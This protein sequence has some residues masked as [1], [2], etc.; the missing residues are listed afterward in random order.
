M[1]DNK[2]AILQQLCDEFVPVTISFQSAQRKRDN[3][4]ILLNNAIDDC[5]GNIEAAAVKVRRELSGEKSGSEPVKTQEPKPEQTQVSKPEPVQE[6]TP[7]P[8]PEQ[9]Q[10]SEPVQAQEPELVQEQTQEQVSEP[11]SVQEQISE[12]TT[13][14]Q[15]TL[16]TDFPLVDE[17][18]PVDT[19]PVSSEPVN[20]EINDD[21]I[22]DDSDDDTDDY[23]DDT[24]ATDFKAVFGL[25]K[26]DDI[27][28][29]IPEKPKKPVKKLSKSKDEDI[30]MKKA[31]VPHSVEIFL[32]SIFPSYTDA[33]FG[34]KISAMAYILS[35][36]DCNEISQR[37]VTIAEDYEKRQKR[38]RGVTVDDIGKSLVRLRNH[39][40]EILQISYETR[41]ATAY[42]ELQR[43]YSRS[44]AP[45]I[46]NIDFFS[47]D[48]QKY[49][50]RLHTLAER[51][52]RS[53]IDAR[54]RE[55]RKSTYSDDENN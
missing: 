5:D 9:T 50:K 4:R 53:E 20:A 25:N 55:I 18:K 16:D 47:D 51:E 13:E 43:S 23:I 2:T 8:E 30:V 3:I 27:S 14:S 29:D 36:H 32:N 28:Q 49:L 15:E 45:P 52:R 24:N 26:T 6:Q 11:E 41:A 19:P 31:M 42:I 12:P 40:L 48:M 21:Y 7:E 38:K 33:S 39:I 10:V 1:A 34:D 17:N 22:N 44:S 54:G 46:D 35:D 37:A